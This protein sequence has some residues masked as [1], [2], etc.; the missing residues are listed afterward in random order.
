MQGQRVCRYSWSFLSLY[1][2]YRYRYNTCRKTYRRTKMGSSRT[3]HSI[4]ITSRSQRL[5]RVFLKKG[6]R[7]YRDQRYRRALFAYT[8]ATHFD[9]R[10]AYAYNGKGDAFYK[11][12]LYGQALIAYEQALHLDSTCIPA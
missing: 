9:P 12:A 3:T 1:S 5:A 11:L 10:N 7:Y 4:N 6:Q 8:R 2:L